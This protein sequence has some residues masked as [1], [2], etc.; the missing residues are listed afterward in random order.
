MGT[1]RRRQ[2]NAEPDSCAREH[3]GRAYPENSWA[4]AIFLVPGHGE[5]NQLQ[6]QLVAP[7]FNG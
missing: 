6:C 4:G 7:Q 1:R 2:V 5:G 3:L